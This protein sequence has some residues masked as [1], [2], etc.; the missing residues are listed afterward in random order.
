M[1]FLQ[2]LKEIPLHISLRLVI[3]KGGNFFCIACPIQGNYVKTLFLHSE[4]KD[5][6][7]RKLD[8]IDKL[9]QR[10][11]KFTSSLPQ[12]EL[13]ELLLYELH[14]I[15]RLP[16]L[17]YD[18]PHQNL[19]EVN[20]SQYEKLQTEPLHAISNHIKSIYQELPFH[21]DK[22]DKSLVAKAIERSFNGKEAKNSAGHCKSLLILC[23]FF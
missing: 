3:R 18:Y 11:V 14:G 23:S 16:S 21:I 1:M 20:L 22:T 2:V 19:E 13:M 8:I 12:K 7:L 5:D 4:K 17:L 15:R 6:N 9:H 10:K